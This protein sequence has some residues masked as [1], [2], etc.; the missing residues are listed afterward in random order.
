MNKRFF[1]R[2]TIVAVAF[3]LAIG[4][5]TFNAVKASAGENGMGYTLAPGQTNLI[6]ADFAD[7]SVVVKGNDADSMAHKFAS[8]SYGLWGTS[9]E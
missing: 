9:Q 5:G 1:S 8:D 4:F 6:G 7:N 3:T 2:L